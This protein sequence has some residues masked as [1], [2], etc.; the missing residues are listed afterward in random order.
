MHTNI[1]PPVP[2]KVK[3]VVGIGLTA[4]YLLGLLSMIFFSLGLGLLL[5]VVSTVGG[6]GFL[7]YYRQ[8]ERQLEE[9]RKRQAGEDARS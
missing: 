2:D 3:A 4:A 5:W 1:K 6:M 8:K 7:Y 9:E